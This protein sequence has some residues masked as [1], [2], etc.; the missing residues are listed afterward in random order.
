M[1]DGEIKS[2][3][4]QERFDN[5]KNSSAFPRDAINW[6]LATNNLNSTDINNVGICSLTVFPQFFSS[7]TEGGTGDSRLR[8][9]FI[10]AE[11]Q[12]GLSKPIR[13]LR[14]FRRTWNDRQFKKAHQELL[15]TL[16]DNW[17]IPREKV[18]FIEHH[19]C[20]AYSPVAFF[21]TEDK[22]WL[23]L[24]MDGMGDKY[25]CTVNVLSKGKVQRISNTGFEH[26]IGYVYSLTTK[27]LGMKP[28]EHEYKVM[29]LAAYAKEGYFTRTYEK[30]FK[31][32]AWL[33]DNSL[34]FDSR[35]PLYRFEEHLRKT[36][37]GERFD[38]IS[39]SLQYFT[40]NLVL[41]WV[42]AAIDKTGIHNVMTSGGVFMNVKLN[43]L[44][45][46]LPE[47][48]DV[49]FMP[50][51]GDESNPVGA[52][53][54]LWAK[55]GKSPATL[56]ENLY[57]GHRFTNDEIRDFIKER[58]LDK[59]YHVEYC[60]NIEARVAKLLSEFK[61]VARFAGQA[62]WGARSLGNRA[63]LANPSDMKSFYTVNDQIKARDFWMPFAPSILDTDV[64]RYL[65]NPKKYDATYMI[66]AF[67]TK[68][69]AH[70]DLRAAMHQGDHTVR[71]QI[72]TEK[73]NPK[74]YRL[75]QDFKNITGI[76]GIL[77]TSLNLHGYP[78][79][80]TLDQALFTFENS[81]L[82]HLALEDYL[83]SK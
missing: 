19:V 17:H 3:V 64:D 22:D 43:K 52:A 20:H 11:Y 74:Y 8:R 29:G 71:P 16:W 50:S 76:G 6:V 14:R 49:R 32:V 5:I 58:E 46:E 23:I 37:V 39:G 78:L 27:F 70:E 61:V 53:S 26:S 7:G 41:Q 9:A 59:N 55:Y 30:V 31:N 2:V 51:C 25:F 13:L 80:S 65:I 68:P 18:E 63:I 79:A 47:V 60:P 21:S 81:G 35:F 82:E 34:E 72:V 69:P 54:V 75:I 4:S 45:Q 12:A 44:I 24:T 42:R 77:N 56:P 10:K 38:N 67:D 83:L 40:E 73:A 62:E 33:K 48:E 1:Q 36:A 57:W 28:Q 66:T 15:D